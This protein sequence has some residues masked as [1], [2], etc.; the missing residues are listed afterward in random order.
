LGTGT[1]LQGT[2]ANIS[3]GTITNAIALQANNAIAGGGTI[4][5]SYGGLVAA[6]TAG[7]NN[8]G[9]AIGDA[10][11]NTLWVNNTNDS[12]DEAGGIVFGS[13]RDTN[14]YRNAANSLRTDDD[15]HV[16]SKLQV[17]TDAFV[18]SSSQCNF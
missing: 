7:T 1:G 15:L 12:T 17:G 6:Q 13:S 2:V 14:L 9:I 18:G 16:A 8:Y 10:G 5:N 11:T 3:T 4:T